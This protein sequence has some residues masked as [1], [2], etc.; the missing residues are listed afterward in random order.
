MHEFP[1]YGLILQNQYTNSA[2]QSVC[3]WPENGF[4]PQRHLKKQ[5]Y[6]HQKG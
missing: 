5:H 3:G 4:K 6:T 2:F 1:P